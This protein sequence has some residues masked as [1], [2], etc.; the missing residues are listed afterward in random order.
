T[1]NAP[2]V[3]ADER[4]TA[5]GNPCDVGAYEG[6]IAP[7]ATQ[8]VVTSLGDPLSICP[9]SSRC[10][11]RQAMSQ[12]TY[13]DTITFG[14]SG[15]ITLAS[16]L[17]DVMTALTIDGTGESVTLSGNQAV[18][19]LR[20]NSGNLT[21][22][23]MTIANGHTNGG[24]LYNAGGIVTIQNSTFYGNVAPWVDYLTF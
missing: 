9:D 6:F 17:P 19:V 18:G 7:A 8:W 10:T 16:T 4:G 21:L 22:R 13:G 15:T 20:V 3:S 12:A 23:S 14:V 24:G 2:S 11:L 5:R 1:P